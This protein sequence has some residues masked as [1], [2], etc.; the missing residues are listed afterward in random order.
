M[1]RRQRSNLRCCSFAPGIAAA[2]M[3]TETAEEQLTLLPSAGAGGRDGILAPG[4]DLFWFPL[5]APAAGPLE[6]FRLG[7]NRL[8]PCCRRV[9][10]T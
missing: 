2:H 9:F 3:R 4:P 5:E 7:P 1:L 8:S 6:P 10:F